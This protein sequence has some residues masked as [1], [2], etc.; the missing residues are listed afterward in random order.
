MM[1]LPP[2]RYQKDSQWDDEDDDDHASDVSVC[3]EWAT[4]RKRRKSFKSKLEKQ[5][6]Q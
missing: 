4:Q 3:V 6:V 2:T 5:C 1:A